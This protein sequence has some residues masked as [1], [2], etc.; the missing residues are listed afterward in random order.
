[1]LYGSTPRS[2]WRLLKSSDDRVRRDQRV[3][4]L[5]HRGNARVRHACP[6]DRNGGERWPPDPLRHDAVH[7]SALLTDTV[8]FG[9]QIN[10]AASFNPD[11][12][13][14]QGRVTARDALA[15]GVP[16]VF[17]PV[18]DISHNPLWPRT[19]ETFGEDPHLTAVM[20]DAIVRG[21]QSNNQSAACFKHWI[22]YSWTDTGHDTDGVAISDFDLLNTFIPA[23]K[24][25]IDAGA[26]TGMENYISVN[27][28][29]VI[30]NTKLMTKLLR[31]DVGF[32]GMMV[33]DFYEIN[34]LPAFFKF[35][36]ELFQ[37]TLHYR[38]VQIRR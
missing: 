9:Q 25:V 30:E 1:M 5:D 24:A 27:G 2:R 13:Y 21:L 11:L 6:A 28:V 15:A 34:D 10:G 37:R 36:R 22:G 16:W 29:L 32:S 4:G 26:L 35:R 8:F 14:E 31:D 23:F 20:G 17:S 33:T 7:S 12:V 19:Y 3:V 38:A 18:L